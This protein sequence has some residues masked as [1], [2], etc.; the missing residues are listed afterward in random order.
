MNTINTGAI[1]GTLLLEVTLF[2][3]SLET[4]ELILL[5]IIRL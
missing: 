5:D 3:K 4:L 1:S 2:H